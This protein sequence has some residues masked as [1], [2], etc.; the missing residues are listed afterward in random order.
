M[1]SR[2]VEIIGGG[3][4]GAFA[5]RLVAL[6]HPD[7]RVRLF[8]RLPPEDTFG[9]G[10]GL[11][12]RLLRAVRA[13]DPDIHERLMAAI[14]PFSSAKFSLPQGDVTFG[15]FHSGAIRRSK[16]LRILVQGAS[17]AGVEVTVGR[18]VSVDELAGDAD[19]VIG[20]DGVASPT[21]TR[22][23][24]DFAP[25]VS[26]GRGVFIWCA[27]EVSLDGT[28]FHPV[29]TPDGTFVAH[30]Y[31]YDEGLSTFVI[32][33]SPA[34]LERA[35]LA[36]RE[37]T[38]DSESDEDSLAYL[39]AA[40]GG[41]LH[42]RQFFG[43]RSRWTRFTTL[44]CAQWYRGNTVLLG[45]AAATVHPSLGSGTKV[46]LESAIALAN[47]LDEIG[48]EPPASVLAAFDRNRR[49][50]VERLQES[51]TRS[52]LWWE[53]FTT[54]QH[55]PGARLAV[56]YLSRAGVVSLTDLVNSMPGLA[57]E[58]AA[59]FAGTAAGEVP[60][61]DLVNWVLRCPLTAGGNGFSGRLLQTPA[62][63][64]AMRPPA[65]APVEVE[66]GDAWGPD[67][68]KYLE[69]ARALA[70]AGAEVIQ[71]IGRAD[72]SA[73]LDRLAVA[74]RLRGELTAAIGVTVD[75]PQL[76]LGADGLV[77]GRADF[78]CVPAMP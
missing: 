49:P 36:G 55:L 73:V 14:F 51:S 69:Q 2:R 7:W 52:Q 16:L 60:G 30:T 75:E 22:F 41:L 10:V 35:G 5:A 48:D 29:E 31:P 65:I 56:S 62:G 37:W 34:I 12:H 70:D 9:F 45:D 44:R 61:D 39:S 21:R 11:T 17:D 59:Q 38:A 54:R 66:S 32:E 42:G 20:A 4:A 50:S 15:Q 25:D 72:R 24:A 33:T 77:A 8:E 6:R 47:E 57:V 64:S 19:L 46:A 26:L 63:G 1:A 18:P 3:P 78:V 68:E 53:S 13:A 67:G 23:A 43:N 76:A 58:A 40:F 74:E 71:L 28:V 27:A